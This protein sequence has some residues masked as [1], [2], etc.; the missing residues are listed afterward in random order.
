MNTHLK[1]LHRVVDLSA[2]PEARPT[3]ARGAGIRLL[4][5]RLLAALLL[6]LRLRLALLLRLLLLLLHALLLLLLL[7]LPLL[8]LLLQ[9]LLLKGS[10]VLLHV[11]LLR[12]HAHAA[13]LRLLGEAGVLHGLHGLHLHLHLQ[14]HARHALRHA[15]GAE[16]GGHALHRAAAEVG[17][18]AGAALLLLASSTA[19]GA[20]HEQRRIES[21]HVEAG[22][23][24]AGA[25]GR[26]GPVH[27]ATAR[28]M[29]RSSGG[30]VGA[31]H[32]AMDV[33]GGADGCDR[34][35]AKGVCEGM[36]RARAKE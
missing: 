5:L 31:M 11:L 35:A 22:A 30:T 25:G 26:A 23:R 18:L 33:G 27:G 34:S 8:L 2:W 21:A 14:V 32:A 6:L 10:E 24:R 36:R 3:A 13:L 29:A 28:W 1:H 16:V 9:Q 17:H 20:G 15:A 19:A 4:L 12:R 7:L